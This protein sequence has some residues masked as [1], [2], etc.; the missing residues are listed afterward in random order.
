MSEWEITQRDKNERGM[1]SKGIVPWFPCCFLQKP[2]LTTDFLS[3]VEQG[4]RRACG[5]MD[6][7]L[8]CH[9]LND[10]GH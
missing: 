10:C 5:I 4:Q 8:Q 1:D 6:L 9:P 3:L 2:E 7:M